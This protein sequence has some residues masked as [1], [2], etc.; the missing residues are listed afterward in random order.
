MSPAP[1]PPSIV[2]SRFEGVPEWAT[3][4]TVDN[5]GFWSET[6]DVESTVSGV[7]Q[8]MPKMLAGRAPLDALLRLL[9]KRF[10]I[11]LSG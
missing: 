10:G 5:H 2:R 7:V 8:A 4:C 3:Y 9:L 6:F 1:A 11:V